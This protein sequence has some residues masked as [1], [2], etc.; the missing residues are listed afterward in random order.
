MRRYDARLEAP[1]VDHVAEDEAL[2]DEITLDSRRVRVR[3]VDL[4]IQT[5]RLDPSNP[6]LANTVAASL[7]SRGAQLQDDLA[8]MLWAD[9]DV[10]ALYHAILK[11]RGLVERIIVRADG[12]VAEGN[13]RTVVYR[14]LAEQ[15][16]ADPT[17]QRIPARVLPDDINER[18]VAI[19]LG[20]LHV[21]G[22]NKWSA[23]EK[24]GHIYKLT[25]EFGYA[26]DEIA[27][28]L[29]MSK[30][31]VNH[32]ARAFTVMREQYLPRYSGAGAP[33]KFSYFVELYKS[34][35]LRDWV[36]RDDKALEDFVSWVG[37]EKLPNGAD[38]RELPD[39]IKNGAALEAFRRDGLQAARHVLELDRPELTSTLFRQMVEMTTALH[40]A[41]L[42]DIQRVRKDQ[43]GS[44]RR[45]VRDLRESLDRFIELCDGI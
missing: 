29:R 43:V 3:C 28:L 14:R 19:L 41:R 40:E 6:R 10:A 1:K 36:A 27:K 33:R 25:N 21:G 34:P 23:F 18:Q 45:I 4:P 20:E 12:T 44:S 5:V 35:E 26:Q 32:H 7:R 15:F 24:A 30:T 16:K 42:D 11:N 2:V 13:C 9:P 22:K 8:A 31:A 37:D 38:V 39:I 17:W